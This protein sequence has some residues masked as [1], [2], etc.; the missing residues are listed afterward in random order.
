MSAKQKQKKEKIQIF[1]TTLRDGEQS[2]GASLT[3]REKVELAHQLELLN[4]DVIEAGFPIASPGDFQAVSEIAKTVKKSTVAGLARCIRKDIDRCAEA[5]APARKGRIHVFLATSA[6]HRKYKLKKARSEILKQAV[7]SIKYAGKHCKDVEFS[8]ED[9]SRTE[10]AFLAQIVEAAID[11]GATTI[12]IPDTV[13]Y[14]IPSEF[15]A[16]IARLFDNVP[17]I[18]DVIV[19]VHCHNDLGLAVA[20]SLA[21]IQN[22]ARGVECTI[23]GLGERAGNAA[24]EEIVMAIRTRPDMFP[25]METC[26]RTERLYKISRLVSRLTGISVQ[27][28][29]A[30]VGANAFAHES[31]VH[32]DGMLKK[33][34]TYEIMRPQDIGKEGTELVLGKHSGR[35]A[36]RHRVSQLGVILNNQELERTYGRFIRL[37]DKKKMIYDDD[38]LM[39]AR[40]EMIDARRVFIL[41]YFNVSTGTDIV[42]TAT[43]RLVKGK[44]TIQEAA[45]GDGP[46]DATLK[47]I[48][49]ITGLKGKLIDFSVQ[50]I[51]IGKD[52]MGEVTIRVQFGDS[53]VN[54]KAASTD[55]IEAGAKAYLSCVNQHLTEKNGFKKRKTKKTT[56]KR[57]STRKK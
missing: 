23:N 52:A 17:N 1:D 37:A 33:S 46:V 7:S 25:N 56:K 49:R 42:P 20:N 44:D 26:I 54:A 2:P 47:A 30:V 41:D 50:A 27:R 12:N 48:E 6:I 38:L 8:P 29:K 14:S 21:A 15:G 19:N 4:V 43:V 13:G 9:A 32:Q 55:I 40:E 28:N 45:C 51:S 31:G 22:G 53:Y 11:A 57:S 39:I 18:G 34:S 35:H 10:P 24:L 3:H 16:V 5:I 36:F